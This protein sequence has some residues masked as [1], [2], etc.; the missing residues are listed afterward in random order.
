MKK[1]IEPGSGVDEMGGG[2][3]WGCLKPAAIIAVIVF[4]IFLTLRFFG[5]I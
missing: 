5:I 4:L 2:I 3:V 1:L